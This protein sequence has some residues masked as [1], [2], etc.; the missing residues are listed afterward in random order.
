MAAYRRDYHGFGH[1]VQYRDL[2]RNHTLVSTV[3]LRIG[4]KFTFTTEFTTIISSLSTVT[5][6]Y[7][8]M[9]LLQQGKLRHHN[10]Q[11][12]CTP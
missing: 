12:G 7:G 1:C 9:Y 3:G 11:A 8:R 5:I 2:L 4:Y 6:H 10:R